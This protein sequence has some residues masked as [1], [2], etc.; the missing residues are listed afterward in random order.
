M[1]KFPFGTSTGQINHR[2][3]NRAGGPTIR[4]GEANQSAETPWTFIRAVE[5]KFGPLGWDLAAT[6]DNKK[7]PLFVGPDRNSL[8]I[9]WHMLARPLV[10]PSNNLCFLNPPYANITVWAKKCAAEVQLGARILLLVPASVGANWFKDLVW[11]YADIYSIGRLVFDNCYNRQG[12]LITTSYPKDLILAHF[13]LSLS[14]GKKL[15]FW[16]DW[17][18]Q[19]KRSG[20]PDQLDAITQPRRIIK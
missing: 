5:D 9:D 3:P 11:P 19:E 17:K 12:Q 6:P 18:R 10:E 8:T 16:A 4:R 2:Q 7:A 20:P 13:D 14:T 1:V 15:L